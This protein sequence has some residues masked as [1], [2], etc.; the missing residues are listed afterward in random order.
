MIEQ[1]LNNKEAV[2][3]LMSLG[4]GSAIAVVAMFL[5]F[6]SFERIIMSRNF[7]RR[8]D[9]YLDEINESIKKISEKDGK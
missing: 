7:N 4:A 9:D 1:I 8:A 3:A 5:A 2:K 6:R